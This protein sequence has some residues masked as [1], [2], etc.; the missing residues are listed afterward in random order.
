METTASFTPAELKALRRAFQVKT[1]TPDEVCLTIRPLRRSSYMVLWGLG[2]AVLFAIGAILPTNS[3]HATRPPFGAAWAL[4]TASTVVLFLLLPHLYRPTFDFVIRPGAR[5]ITMRG[6]G[7]TQER[8]AAFCRVVDRVF[9]CGVY[10]DNVPYA[11]RRRWWQVGLTRKSARVLATTLTPAQAELMAEH[12]DGNLRSRILRSTDRTLWARCFGEAVVTDNE[13][14][15]LLPPPAWHMW[16]MGAASLVGV[17]A[18]LAWSTILIKLWTT[19][20]PTLAEAPMQ[21]LEAF[22]EHRTRWLASWP[23]L[24]PPS[25]L[26]AIVA[27]VSIYAD[28]W[29]RRAVAVVPRGQQRIQIRIGGR[30]LTDSPLLPEMIWAEDA[31]ERESDTGIDRVG[32]SVPGWHGQRSC[33][34]KVGLIQAAVDRLYI[35]ASTPASPGEQGQA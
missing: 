15:F 21:V 25:L 10:V 24:L 3:G 7:F 35:W 9:W 2:L 30:Q 17:V 19:G 18:L 13:A 6:F 26:V 11:I 14:V 12:C 5:P 1:A 31:N 28:P 27:T 23:T 4:A 32:L 33:R 20:P 16:W 8:G 34:L 29:F 22:W